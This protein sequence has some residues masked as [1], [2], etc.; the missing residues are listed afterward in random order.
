MC[1]KTVA[2]I[3]AILLALGCVSATA[4]V[5]KQEKVY[6]VAGVDGTISGWK[7]RTAWTPLQIRPS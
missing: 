3:L 4:E 7:T 1:K 5:N 2:M 6:V